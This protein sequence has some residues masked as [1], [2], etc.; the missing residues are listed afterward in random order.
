MAILVPHHQF[1][2]I[3]LSEGRPDA[4]SETGR[5][6]GFRGGG[7]GAGPLGEAPPASTAV[8]HVPEA[9]ARGGGGEQGTAS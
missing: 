9:A 8:P 1:C 5:G 6:R 4:P 7:G 3:V 2:S